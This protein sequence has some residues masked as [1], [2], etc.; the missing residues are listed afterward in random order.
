MKQGV[1]MLKNRRLLCASAPLKG[2]KRKGSCSFC[3]EV[4]FCRP[5]KIKKSIKLCEDCFLDMADD[6]YRRIETAT[7]QFEGS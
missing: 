4:V 6:V 1:R 5:Q 2:Y 3:G 7:G